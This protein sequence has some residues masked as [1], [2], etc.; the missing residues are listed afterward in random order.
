MSLD[1]VR[2]RITL[3]DS[4]TGPRNRIV[5]YDWFVRGPKRAPPRGGHQVELLI[6]GEQTWSRVVE[7]LERAREEIQISMW[8]ARPDMEL[9]RPAKLAVS[10]P[11]ERAELRLGA[12]LERRAS[13]GVGVRLLIWG[14]VYTPILDPWL[15]RW[16]WRRSANIDVLEQDHP[17]VLGSIHQKTIT[18]DGRIG[19]CGGMNLKQNDWDTSEHAIFEPRRNPYSVGALRRSWVAK[20]QR[21]PAYLPRH[22]LAVRIEGPAVADLLDDFCDR[23]AQVLAVR[24]RSLSGRI[25]DGL[26]TPTRELA[27]PTHTPEPCGDCWVQVVRT[28][29]GGEDGILGAYVRAIRN[30]RRY[31]YIENQYFRSPL[32]GEELREAIRNNPA[33]RLAVVVR[34][35]ND[36]DKS[37]IDPSGYWTAHTLELIREVRPE[38]QLTRLIVWARDAE[39]RLVWQDVDVHAKIM[40]VDDVWLTV[41]SANIHDRGFR[42]EGELN[43]VVLDKQLARELRKRL[44][45][46]HLEIELAD[47][48]LCAIETAFDLWE[49]HA[50]LNPQLR[51]R[52]QPPRSR[53][54]HFVQQGLR[55]PP[56]GVGS[57]LF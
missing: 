52:G 57:G 13:E 47:P 51:E 53:V 56:F 48:R 42:S 10:E 8:M 27:A 4:A 33:L 22:D 34:P 49:Q 14:V 54:H 24:R 12:M 17:H 20:R 40:I 44:M 41:G 9:L 45:A 1:V 16:Y 36:G 37:M 39:R 23:W 6:D 32:I 15:R 5:I 25:V 3:A 35:V 43:V 55:R 28:T 46:E 30:A 50:D 31:I 26:R 21:L 29:P 19:Y 7:D 2:F 11:S 18:I 38:F